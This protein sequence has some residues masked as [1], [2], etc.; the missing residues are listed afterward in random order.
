M[1]IYSWIGT[2]PQKETLQSLDQGKDGTEKSD[3]SL[4]VRALGARQVESVGSSF[5]TQFHSPPCW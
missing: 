1:E 5:N 4:G 2:F 3:F